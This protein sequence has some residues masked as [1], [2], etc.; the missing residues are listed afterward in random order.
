[1]CC[2]VLSRTEVIWDWLLTEPAGLLF[3]TPVLEQPQ[4]ES[5]SKY[6]PFF[7]FFLLHLSI[8]AILIPLLVFSLEQQEPRTVVG[9]AERTGALGL[10]G[11]QLH[12]VGSRARRWGSG[13]RAFG[14]LWKSLWRRG[15]GRADCHIA[16]K[17]L[18]V[19]KYL[20]YRS[21]PHWGPLP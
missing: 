11:G 4:G 13:L 17:D 2:Q 3:P 6:N 21:A 1:M 14:S 19:A 16:Q 8:L 10:R 18:S 7:F 9:Q 12:R 15:W 20:P 5:F